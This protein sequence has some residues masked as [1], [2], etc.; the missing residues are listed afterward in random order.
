MGKTQAGKSTLVQFVK[1]YVDPKYQIDRKL[2]GGGNVALTAEPIRFV[3]VSHLPAYE[4]IE[5][6]GGAVVNLH[7]LAKFGTDD[8]FQ[9]VL[10]YREETHELRKVPQD[11]GGM[12]TESVEL[13]FLDTPGLNDTKSDD[14]VHAENILKEVIATRSFNLILFVFKHDSP[15]TKEQLIALNY[16][17]K[18][19][20]ELQSSI[21]LVF[22][23]VVYEN[24]HHSNPDHQS[25]I[26][27]R[28]RIYSLLFRRP[29]IDPCSLERN[30]TTTDE[31]DGTVD[32]P[33]FTIDFVAGK[34]PV[35]QWMIKNTI[36]EMLSL[37]VNKTPAVL[38]TSK[39][40]IDRLRAIVHPTKEND[41]QRKN[42][43]IRQAEVTS[44][45]GPVK[46]TEPT[47][48]SGSLEI[49]EVEINILLIGDVQSGKSSLVETMKLYADPTYLIDHD[50][51]NRSV[52][53][54]TEGNVRITSFLSEL[55][56]VE[57]RKLQV[58]D[59]SHDLV[60]FEG[61]SKTLSEE[62][63]NDF[64]KQ[65]AKDIS[66][67][68]VTQESPKQYRFN[69]YEGPSLNESAENFE[70]NIYC[71]HKTI[72]ES[73]KEF[74][75]VLFALAPGPI[76][77]AIRTTLRVC[78][79]VF[80]DLNS[81]F[82]FV[83]TKID[84]SRLHVSNKQFREFVQER[85]RILWKE[86]HEQQL[87]KQQGT[88]SRLN[89]QQS[90]QSSLEPFLIDC[91]LQKKWPI[92]HAK[93]QNVVREILAAA[94]GQTEP[95]AMASALMRKTPR[96]I[97]IDT[98]LKWTIKDEFQSAKA[99]IVENSHIQNS[100]MSDLVK[101]DEN[102]AVIVQSQTHSAASNH[103]AWN[104]GLELVH[105][106]RYEA[107]LKKRAVLSSRMMDFNG[108]GR[109][110]ERLVKEHQNIEIEQ[111]IGGEGYD[112][113]MI[114]YR[115]ETGAA[116]HLDVKLYSRRIVE[117]NSIEGN[118]V[119]VIALRQRRDDLA[120]KLSEIEAHIASLSRLQLEYYLMRA[121]ISR[122]SLPAAVMDALTKVQAYGVNE[123][124][125]A[126]LNDIRRIYLSTKGV[127][128]TDLSHTND[129][130]DYEDYFLD[131]SDASDTESLDE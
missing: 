24:C 59:G 89:T 101:L 36:R 112:H 38:D 113:W 79:D 27:K 22:T 131:N 129:E 75:Q 28:R 45:E 39:E 66:V 128:S 85:Q 14:C 61:K 11:T 125:E 115:Q 103:G 9:E 8:D 97:A 30:I 33:C 98:S 23:H 111:E 35:K 110:I 91:D 26:D 71:I 47:G 83:H 99:A 119:N 107:K 32:F 5:K 48:C 34:R 126:P 40:N 80:S 94:V 92:R 116:S 117:R 96:M 57:I 122:V 76:T 127:Y 63:F 6:E 42:N 84:Y 41:E 72:A 46:D 29:D 17:A 102:I 93:T 4:V 1:N 58:I 124:S 88:N 108:R 109:T 3:V 95:V 2:I 67:H 69:I 90:M 49:S 50:R 78:S 21:A 10:S 12:S 16:Y 37:A 81:L 52:L 13:V 60:D 100:L 123:V 55:P 114:I 121:W 18:V 20:K 51:I 44:G 64:L 70:K 53:Y 68:V 86:I 105:S 87:H 43:K 19:L 106:D 15:M 65:T 73:K 118:Y 130:D 54:S 62:D 120:H 31:K 74:H 82:S 77:S 56:T 104:E 25:G 7:S